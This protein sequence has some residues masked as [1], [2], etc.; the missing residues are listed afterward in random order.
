MRI[1]NPFNL[2]FMTAL[3]IVGFAVNWVWEMAQMPAYVETAERSW[4]E[5]A[6]QCAAFSVGDAAL[7]SAIYAIAVTTA[8]RIRSIKGLKLYLL[9]SALGAIAAMFIELTA[10]AMGYWTYSKSMPIVFGLGL[11]PILQLTT[12]AP[13]TVWIASRWKG[14]D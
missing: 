12:L 6:L 5:T 7:I 9:V 13:L 3:L 2:S 8:R 4:R 10:S 11:L 14:A 1:G